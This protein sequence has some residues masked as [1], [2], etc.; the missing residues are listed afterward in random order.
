V[1]RDS[2]LPVSRDSPPPVSRDSQRGIHVGRVSLFVVNNISRN[3]CSNLMKLSEYINNGS[4]LVSTNLGTNWF[5]IHIAGRDLLRLLLLVRRRRSLQVLCFS[6][7]FCVFVFYFLFFDA[8]AQQR[9]RLGKSRPAVTAGRL[10]PILHQ[11][12]YVVRPWKS[13]P[14]KIVGVP[15]NVHFGSK[16]LDSAVFG[17][18][19]HGNEEEEF[20]EN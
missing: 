6:G 16:H 4:R 20:W 13:V 11:R 8:T 15:S 2:P 12:L 10:L 9:L 17:R 5:K 1:S 7:P 14:L 19:L 18:P 3:S